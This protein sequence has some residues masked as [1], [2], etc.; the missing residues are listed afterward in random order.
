VQLDIGK[1]GR[2]V[3]GNEEVEFALGSLN[4]GNINMKIANWIGFEFLLGRLVTLD[5]RRPANVVALPAPVQR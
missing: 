3:D 4:L 2:P 1:L 5:L